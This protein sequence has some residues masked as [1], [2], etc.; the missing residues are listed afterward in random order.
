LIV[1]DA[2]AA[3]KWFLPEAGS[4]EAERLLTGSRKLLAPDLI[5]IEV[6]G[7]LVRR[8]RLG[9]LTVEQARLLVAAWVRAITASAV[10]L[11]PAEDDMEQAVEL[12]LR[13]G[14]PLADCLYLALAMRLDVP[15]VTADR[16][17]AARAVAV[18]PGAQDLAPR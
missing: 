4:E 10:T 6:A 5:R 8:V 3:V 9:E 1:V 7:A 16:K 2:S 17:F 15:L 13:L 12:A 11:V 18:H 14:H